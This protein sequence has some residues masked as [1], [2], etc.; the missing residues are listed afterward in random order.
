MIPENGRVQMKHLNLANC[1]FIP[2]N[3]LTEQEFSYGAVK[4]VAELVGFQIILFRKTGSK[5]NTVLSIDWAENFHPGVL[6]LAQQLL[7][8]IKC[9]LRL[10]DDR[11]KVEHLYGKADYSD[12][13][14][15]DCD[16]LYYVDAGQN[17]L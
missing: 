8:Q 2:K 3:F 16:Q 17:T 1:T 4:G 15:V 14:N 11:K 6:D 13:I 12:D 9:P 10:E 5:K 7:V